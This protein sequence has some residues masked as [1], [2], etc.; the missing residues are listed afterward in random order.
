MNNKRLKKILGIL[1]LT[2]GLILMFFS[3]IN[4]LAAVIGSGAG[5]HF[6]PGIIK[7]LFIAAVFLI[8]SMGAI[9]FGAKF[10]NE[11]NPALD[12]HSFPRKSAVS[13]LSQVV[14]IFLLFK[15]CVF[16]F[17]LCMRLF[18]THSIIPISIEQISSII[19]WGSLAVIFYK[20]GFTN[21][22]IKWNKFLIFCL[23]LLV[24]IKLYFMVPSYTK[25]ALFPG[26]V[27]ELLPY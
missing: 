5:R 1:M 11:G 13:L 4:F 10:I 12:K 6:S 7:V 3:F 23:I 9:I 8:L 27:P 2:A 16:V 24:S 22:P 14:F 20:K 15:I 18:S 17:M 19:L 21:S 26:G 25:Y